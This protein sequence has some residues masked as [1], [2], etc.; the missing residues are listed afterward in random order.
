MENRHNFY[1]LMKEN[2]QS[3]KSPYN[4]IESVSTS[5]FR[6][7]IDCQVILANSVLLDSMQATYKEATH[8]ICKSSCV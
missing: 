1:H 7:K 8:E 4:N 2:Q 3:I 6:K 5:D